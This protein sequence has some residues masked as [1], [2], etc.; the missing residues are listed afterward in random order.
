MEEEGLL[1]FSE[2]EGYIIS[3]PPDPNASIPERPVFVQGELPDVVETWYS[4]EP[5]CSV[6]QA[7]PLW[8]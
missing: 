3:P 4:P 8:I 1:H 6:S 7:L 5:C 2:G